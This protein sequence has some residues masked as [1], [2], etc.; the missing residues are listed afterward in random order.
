[1]RVYATTVIRKMKW[2]RDGEAKKYHAWDGLYMRAVIW[3]ERLKRGYRTRSRRK[4][5]IKIE[6]KVAK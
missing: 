5:N 2:R 1:M 3:K 4:D 6:A